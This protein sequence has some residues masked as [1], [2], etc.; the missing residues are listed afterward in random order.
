MTPGKAPPPCCVPSAERLT[1]LEGSR[2]ISASRQRAV[3]G[4]TEHMAK[5]DGGHFWMG[6]EFGEGFP[7]DGEGPIRKVTLDPFYIDRQPVMNHQFAEFVRA[8]GYRTESERYGWSFVF[9]THV[10]A[11]ARERAPGTEWWAKVNGAT[12][13]HPEGLDSSVDTRQNHP[14]VHVSWRDAAAYA[15]WAGKRLPTEAEWEY[16]ARGGLRTENLC[17]GR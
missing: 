5:L 7:A 9:H 16:A 2:R 17:L 6:T 13:A 4:S 14:V 11:P 10:T 8:T 12:W 1:L 3:S 15:Q